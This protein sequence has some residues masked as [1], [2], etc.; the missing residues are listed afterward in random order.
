M[1]F[2]DK[3]IGPLENTTCVKVFIKVFLTIVKF[4]REQMRSQ[5]GLKVRR[6]VSM[7]GNINDCT[8]RNLVHQHSRTSN[9]K[10]KKKRTLIAS[11]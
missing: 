6:S 9:V 2:Y 1:D 8:S 4:I 3:S 5:R 10:K 7:H 11:P